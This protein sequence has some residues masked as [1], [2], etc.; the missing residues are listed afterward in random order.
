MVVE[1]QV[2]CLYDGE[3]TKLDST[4]CLCMLRALEKVMRCIKSMDLRTLK[5]IT[6]TCLILEPKHCTELGLCNIQCDTF[7]L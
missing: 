7:V 5:Y 6:L 4:N 3:L 2:A 1:E